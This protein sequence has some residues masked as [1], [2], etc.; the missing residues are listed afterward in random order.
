MLGRFPLPPAADRL[1]AESFCR[2]IAERG[3]PI[4]A[5]HPDLAYAYE[6]Q[7]GLLEMMLF[8]DLHPHG[9]PGAK[10]LFERLDRHELKTLVANLD[11]WS[12]EAK[13]YTPIGGC[14]LHPRA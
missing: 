5:V 2:F 3:G 12:L 14:T 13:G 7:P 11:R 1:T 6:H 9:L 10:A 4:L 8:P